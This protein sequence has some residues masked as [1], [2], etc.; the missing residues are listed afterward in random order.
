MALFSKRSPTLA[1]HPDRPKEWLT[2]K[3]PPSLPR[4]RPQTIAQFFAILANLSSQREQ[5]AFLRLNQTPH[6]LTFRRCIID[7]SIP[8][9]VDGTNFRWTR[10]AA[11]T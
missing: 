8:W 9:I 3:S 5:I 10:D 11:A 1:N 6:L 2:A 4:T 7:P